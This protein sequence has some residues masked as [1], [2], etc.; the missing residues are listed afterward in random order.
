MSQRAD[1]TRE[2]TPSRQAKGYYTTEQ[3]EVWDSADG[4]ATGQYNESG[5]VD[6]LL[7]HTVPGLPQ[8]GQ[9]HPSLG[10]P[11]G[12]PL[13]VDVRVIQ[14]FANW[15][16]LVLVTYRGWGLYT[17]GPRALTGVAG[18]EPLRINIPIYQSFN[19][20]GN[21][22]TTYLYAPYPWDRDISLRI[23]TRFV[24][25]NAA[26]AVQDAIDLNTGKWY[27]VGTIPQPRY[28]LLSGSRCSAAY[29]G[30]AYT[31]VSYAFICWAAHPGVV[32]GHPRYHNAV[33]VPP[34]NGLQGWQAR[35]SPGPNLAPTVDI[36]DY[37]D[38]ASA[39]GA[40]PGYP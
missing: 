12:T 39:G 36:V 20:V 32:V 40:L 5:L 6:P 4:T 9:P 29:D 31:R 27:N 34:I 37:S 15:S 3:W 23:E 13:V 24:P 8:Y 17:G 38:N 35:P 18:L 33:A 30:L 10:A 14:V 26:N 11:F 22:V 16:Y 21:T 7:V 2:E 1:K 28:A 25:G 19:N